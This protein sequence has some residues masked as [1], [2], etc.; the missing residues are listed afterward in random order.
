MKE[1]TTNTKLGDSAKNGVAKSES[2]KST[3]NDKGKTYEKKES[4]SA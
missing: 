3:A 4:V 1:P 2:E